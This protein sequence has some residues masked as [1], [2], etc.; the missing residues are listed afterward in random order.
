MISR[1]DSR[2]SLTIASTFTAPDR[3]REP[4]PGGQ[5]A[6]SG[7]LGLNVVY[8]PDNG[9][10]VDIIFIHGLGGTSKWT[11]SKHRNSELF[12]PLTFLPLEQD[13]CLARILTFGYNASFQKAGNVSLSLLDFAKDLLF[14]LK[15]GKDPDMDELDMGKVPI[16]FVVH[17]MG[18]LVVKEASLDINAKGAELTIDR[19][20]SK[21]K[22]TQNMHQSS[23]PLQPS[24][25]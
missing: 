8:T 5:L 11:W 14:D 17:S 13:L 6:E 2:N 24:H 4:S 16:I 7:P 12:W 19:L 22:T 18:G 9:R 1:A 15:Y 23:K 21:G 3:R 10:K 20:I 25:F